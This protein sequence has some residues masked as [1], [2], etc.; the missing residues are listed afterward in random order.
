MKHPAPLTLALIALFLA[1]QVIGLFVVSKY[2]QFSATG[3]V[4]YR[5]LPYDIERPQ[6]S[7]MSAIIMIVSAI[8]VGTG[9]LLI[10]VKF[11]KFSLWKIWYFLSIFLTLA[12]AISAFIPQAY[13]AVIALAAAIFKAFKPNLI[14]HNL[15]E[16]LI[17]GGLAAIFVPMLNV[18]AAA[19]L[20][21]LISAYDAYAVW[22]SKH[23]VT[24]AKFQ[25]SSGVFAGLALPYKMGSGPVKLQP[26]SK[27]AS[28]EKSSSGSQSAIIGGGDMGFP[29]MFAGVV[30]LQVGLAKA[31]IIPAAATIAL[32]GL[33]LMGKKGHFYPAMPFISIG[34][35]VGYGIILL[36]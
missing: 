9:I 31:M 35:F 22:K 2:V 24:L 7:P 5:E 14:I 21:L 18:A 13:A 12:V 32:A 23:M 3:E 26:P 20:L 16:L 29:L 8:L 33:L 15:T 27:A 4:E 36:L 34:C 6:M 28:P 1:S 30:M 19:I 17:Y 10:I 25:T 11:K